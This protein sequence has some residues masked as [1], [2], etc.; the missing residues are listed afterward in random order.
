MANSE[1]HQFYVALFVLEQKILPNIQKLTT[2]VNCHN[3]RHLIDLEI[4]LH[5]EF[6]PVAQVFEIHSLVHQ[7]TKSKIILCNEKLVDR[8]IDHSLYYLEF[9]DILL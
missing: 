8:L 6:S 2:V 7:L 5:L 9:V 3:L 4:I 1:S